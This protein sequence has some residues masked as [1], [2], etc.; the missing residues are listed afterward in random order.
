M[1]IIPMVMLTLPMLFPTITALG[2]DPIWFGVIMVIMMEMGQITPPV[3]VNVYV[4]TGVAKD[5]PMGDCFSWNCALHRRAGG[6]DCPALYLAADCHLASQ[7]HG[8][9]R[10]D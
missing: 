8:R 9:P 6:N 10:S 5:V 2:Y 4:I 3:G 1:N 7:H